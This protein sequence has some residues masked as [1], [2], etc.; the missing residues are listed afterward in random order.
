MLEVWKPIKGTDGLY[1]VSNTG[2]VRSLNYGNTG[3]TKELKLSADRLTGYVRVRVKDMNENVMLCSVHRLVAEAFIPNPD[4]LPCVNHKDEDKTN[5]DV[6]N[7][8]WCTQKENA[9]YSSWKMRGV[10]KG[11]H[12]NTGEHHIT[13]RPNGKHRVIIKG[14]EYGSFMDIKKAIKRRD[15][16]LEAMI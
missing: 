4:N 12:T 13:R 5:N 8:E 1:E 14:K 9:I 11:N 3:M 6:S 15:E 10:R 16:V 2:K 7:L